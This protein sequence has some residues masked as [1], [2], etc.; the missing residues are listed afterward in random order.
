ME[1]HQA[2][3]RTTVNG[4]SG[5]CFGV[6]KKAFALQ[7]QHLA[8]AF[9]QLKWKLAK[10]AELKRMGKPAY[11]PQVQSLDTENRVLLGTGKSDTRTIIDTVETLKRKC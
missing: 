7:T 3:A 6:P 11:D 2:A 5:K 10:L 4:S 9:S 1:T 8:D